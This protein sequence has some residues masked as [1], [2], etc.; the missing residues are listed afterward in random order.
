[1]MKLVYPVHTGLY[2]NLTN[3]CPCACTFCIRQKNKKFYVQDSLWL[4]HE[5]NFEEIKASLLA[6]D[7][8]KY[9]E[10]VFCGFGEPTEALDLLLET[11]K[12][13]KSKTDKPIRI[14]T[15]GLGNLINKKNITPLF[16]GLI[17][18]VSISL[19][20]SEARIYEKNVR[21]IYK[22]EA[23]P[24]LIEF[25][26]EVRKY[27]PNVT[28]TTVSSTITHEDEENCRK[29]CEQLGVK[30]RIRKFVN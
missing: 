16:E 3:R 8:N 14:N 11:A 2:L 9:S 24:A 4:D 29:L 5:P 13:L 10:F 22:E 1:M 27:V 28:M 20:S 15:N 26:R 7:L 30:Y 17:D 25:T 6:E 19:N 23:Y 21:P 12:F 18:A